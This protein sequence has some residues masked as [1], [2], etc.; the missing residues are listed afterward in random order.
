MKNSL[1]YATITEWNDLDYSLSNAPSINVLK[2]NIF[3]FI[4][5]GPNNVFNILNPHGVKLLMRLR[6]D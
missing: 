5:L 1:F 4:R 2:Q 6:L 3:K